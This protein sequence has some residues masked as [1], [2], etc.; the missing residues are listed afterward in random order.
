M[1]S[2]WT[3]LWTLYL[4]KSRKLQRGIGTR[5]N[6]VRN[7]ASKERPQNEHLQLPHHVYAHTPFFV[8]FFLS[9][10]ISLPVRSAFYLRLLPCLLPNQTRHRHDFHTLKP[11]W[12]RFKHRKSPQLQ[13][14]IVSVKDFMVFGNRGHV[15]H[16][17]MIIPE[18]VSLE[19]RR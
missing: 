7:R 11:Q 1:T 3:R 10:C 18:S 15:I 16:V 12:K 8:S 2:L 5:V 9:F 19:A 4:L 14:L 6:E 13:H 17:T